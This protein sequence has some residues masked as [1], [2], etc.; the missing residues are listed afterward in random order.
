MHFPS[1]DEEGLESV[2]GPITC[3]G[4]KCEI[5]YSRSGEFFEPAAL[6]ILPIAA[7]RDCCT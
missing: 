6:H 4:K 7:I 1:Q 5:T 2:I 3:Q